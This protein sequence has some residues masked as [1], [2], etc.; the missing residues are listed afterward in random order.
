VAADLPDT[1]TPDALHR[2]RLPARLPPPP[3]SAALIL[4]QNCAPRMPRRFPPT[5][6]AS[7]EGCARQ[8]PSTPAAPPVRAPPRPTGAASER[9]P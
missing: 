3:P 2:Y 1:P 8:A 4:R 6:S 5:P 9:H 7:R